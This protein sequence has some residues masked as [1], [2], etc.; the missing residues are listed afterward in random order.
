MNGFG[1]FIWSSGKSYSGYYKNDLKDGLGLF[2]WQAKSELYYGFWKN[3]K[4]DGP[5]IKISKLTK[6]LTFWEQDKQVAI[7]ISTQE[8]Y[9]FCLAKSQKFAKFFKIEHDNII[10]AIIDRKKLIMA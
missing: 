8:A 3:G 5:A 2:Y 10:K 9:T 1:D 7:F 6:S 4:R